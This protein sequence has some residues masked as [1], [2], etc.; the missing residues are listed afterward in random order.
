MIVSEKR[1]N[2]YDVYQKY[3][4][5]WCP[6]YIFLEFRYFINFQFAIKE[7]WCGEKKAGLFVFYGSCKLIQTNCHN[8]PIQYTYMSASHSCNLMAFRK[9]SH[10]SYKW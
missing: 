7:S 5:E 1:I 9:W 6:F 3:D 2:V 10:E 4:W 8:T